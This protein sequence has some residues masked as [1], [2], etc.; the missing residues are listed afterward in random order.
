MVICQCDASLQSVSSCVC[1]LPL[2]ELLLSSNHSFIA[3]PVVAVCLSGKRNPRKFS[4]LCII[5]FGY[6]SDIIV[7]LSNPSP[8]WCK[9]LL[10]AYTAPSFS[11]LASHAT[12]G[13]IGIITI[14]YSVAPAT[15]LLTC[16]SLIHFKLHNHIHFLLFS[17]ITQFSSN[18][19]STIYT[20]CP[21]HHSCQQVT[22]TVPSLQPQP[23]CHLQRVSLPP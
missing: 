23:S 7:C 2:V 5:G 10:L 19:L 14:K 18:L 8:P 11:A 17:F 20:V 1:R 16:S 21:L 22:L 9:E 15:Q 4:A 3:I 13:I 6:W 12:I